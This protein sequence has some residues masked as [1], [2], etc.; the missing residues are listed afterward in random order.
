VNT[1]PSDEFPKS[2]DTASEEKTTSDP[3][4][5]DTRPLSEDDEAIILKRLQELGYVE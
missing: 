3:I 1:A 2:A 4:E 5:A